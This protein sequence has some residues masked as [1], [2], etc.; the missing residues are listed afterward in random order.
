MSSTTPTTSTVSPYGRR[1][2]VTALILTFAS[3]TAPAAEPPPDLV[4]K[5]ADR[6]AISQEARSQY[7]YKQTVTVEDF[8]EKG[9]RAGDYRE[10]REVIFTPAGE[11]IERFVNKPV[12][13]LKRLI[14]TEEDFA[15]IRNVQPFLFTPDV[16][17]IYESKFRGE[18]TVDG[19]DCWVLQVRPRQILQGQRFFDGVFWVDKTDHS[20]IRSEGK[21]VPQLYSSRAGKENLFPNFTTVR[22]KI[23]EHWFP[24]Q[25]YADDTLYFATGPQRIRLTVRYADYRKFAAE[26]KIVP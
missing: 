14:L 20:I 8:N 9:G 13:R 7:L 3:L 21:A 5:V 2:A 4:K 23:G 6:E 11:R 19:I 25:T 18:E 26:S 24:V 15:D 22:R 17:F 12:N 10:V 16:A 1:E